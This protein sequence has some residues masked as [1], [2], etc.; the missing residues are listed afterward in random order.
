MSLHGLRVDR[1]GHSAIFWS[2]VLPFD[3]ESVLPDSVRQRK[4]KTKILNVLTG[5][6]FD[7]DSSP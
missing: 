4:E 5:L 2:D 3:L 6:G 7:Q 1:L